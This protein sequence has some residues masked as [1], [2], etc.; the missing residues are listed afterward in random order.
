MLFSVG[1][2]FGWRGYA[3]PRL[4]A[5]FGAA[6]GALVVGALWGLWHLSM[7]A[8]PTGRVPHLDGLVLSMIDFALNSVVLAWVFERS[9]RSMAVA[10]AMHAGG[11]LD[12]ATLI[13]DSDA[14]L[15]TA[16]F[17]LLGLGAALAS[18]DLARRPPPDTA[19]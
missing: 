9:G 2:E 6:H 19:T 12:N 10:I 7:T 17:V 18:W 8:S 1:E 13:P 15:R 4:A 5:R 14:F 16:R 11:H 3:Y